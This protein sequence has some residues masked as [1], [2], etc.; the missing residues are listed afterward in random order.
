[1]MALNYENYRG[2]I[3]YGRETYVFM[4]AT[5]GDVEQIAEMY[6]E[7]S[8]N[9][10][11]YKVKL[12][13]RHEESFARTGG[14]FEIH[15]RESIEKEMRDGKSFF[16]IAKSLGGKIAA[17]FWFG[18]KNSHLDEFNPKDFLGCQS[19]ESSIG[20][21]LRNGTMAYPLELICRPG[22]LHNAAHVMF[23]TIF[24]T[25][26]QNGYTHSLFEVY[27]LR[28]YRYKG[29][30]FPVDMLNQR[31]F[32]MSV[33]MGGKF[34]G[35]LPDFD[36]RLGQLSVAISPKVICCDYAEV[37]PALEKKLAD[38]GI[39]ITFGQGDRQ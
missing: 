5:L 35:S 2:E 31:S 26:R 14:M 8:I 15:T 12:D 23:Y 34:I 17:S 3:V 28:G 22:K 4:P 27:A 38:T 6:D 36:I 11:N 37:L 19:C 16:A 13:P 10:G 20:Q 24:N 7:I 1:M 32:D 30:R 29:Q 21:A 9:E 25:L 33:G 39:K 18:P